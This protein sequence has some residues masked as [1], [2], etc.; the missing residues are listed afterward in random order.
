M[1]LKRI[2]EFRANLKGLN[3]QRNDKIVE[4]QGLVNKAKGET[5]AMSQEEQ[6]KFKTLSDEVAAI[7][8]KRRQ[9]RW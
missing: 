8:A 3:E 5:R 6:D 1:I 2:P 9:K 7:D 4:M